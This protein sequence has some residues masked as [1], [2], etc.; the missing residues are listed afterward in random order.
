GRSGAVRAGRR[1]HPHAD[2]AL[3][4]GAD[5][6]PG[7]GAFGPG[8]R[9]PAEDLRHVTVTP[10]LS[11]SPIRAPP[12]WHS[13]CTDAEST[14][15]TMRKSTY[16]LATAALAATFVLGGVARAGDV[17]IVNPQST[18]AAPPAAPPP[19]VVPVQEP[20]P[21]VV[22]PQSQRVIHE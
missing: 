6:P 14:E 7:L 4:G 10:S 13:R 8:R 21:V 18:T 2:R 5:L 9:H 15:G 3:R 20:A 22:P 16:L 12:A 19:A 11:R 1:R 17:E